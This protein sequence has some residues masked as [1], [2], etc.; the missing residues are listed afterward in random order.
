MLDL[1]LKLIENIWKKS[2]DMAMLFPKE[3]ATKTIAN[4]DRQ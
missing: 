2:L 3:Q 4:R 1:K